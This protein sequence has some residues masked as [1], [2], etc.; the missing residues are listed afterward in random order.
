MHVLVWGHAHALVRMHAWRRTSEQSPREVA[1]KDMREVPFRDPRADQRHLAGR[2]KHESMRIRP[3]AGHNVVLTTAYVSSRRE[4][5]GY[6]VY[7]GSYSLV[8]YIYIIIIHAQ[9]AAWR[10]PRR[11]ARQSSLMGVGIT[12]ETIENYYSFFVA[13]PA[14]LHCS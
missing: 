4:A 10:G 6:L 9:H 1:G 8:T 12:M 7:L 3:H 5:R 2:G 14:P 11:P 13:I